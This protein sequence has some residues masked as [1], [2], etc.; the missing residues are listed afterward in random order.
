MRLSLQMNKALLTFDWARRLEDLGVG[1]LLITS[2][3]KEG[4]WEGFD[5]DLIK[6]ISDSVEIPVIAHGGAGTVEHIGDAI[7]KGNASAVAL[8]SMVV[9]QK[10]NMGVLVNFPSKPSLIRTLK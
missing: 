7:K 1:E 3:D 10:K 8:G 5:V 9:Y 4:T 2:V 6:V